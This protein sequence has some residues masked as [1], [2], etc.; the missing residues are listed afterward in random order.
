M[1]SYTDIEQSKK[2]NRT[3]YTCDTC[4]HKGNLICCHNCPKF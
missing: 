2:L 3:V 1:K 4:P